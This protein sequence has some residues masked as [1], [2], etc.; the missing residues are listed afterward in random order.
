MTEDVYS[1]ITDRIVASL[2]QGVRPWHRPWNAEHAAGRITRPLRCN[3][4]PYSGINVVMLWMEAVEAGYSAPIWMTFRQAKELGAHVRRGEHGAT[5]VYASTFRKTEED[6]ETG[7][8]VERDIP[9]MKGYRVFNVEQ[10]EGLPA[11]Y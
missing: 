5:V 6:K 2:E 8:E 9:F 10:I 7:E 4:Q 3:G 11:H 1:R